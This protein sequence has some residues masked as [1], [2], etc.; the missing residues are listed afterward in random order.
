MI[1]HMAAADSP[2]ISRRSAH[3]ARLGKAD[4]TAA[5]TGRPVSCARRLEDPTIGRHRPRRLAAPRP[6]ASEPKNTTTGDKK[7]F[8]HTGPV[9]TTGGSTTSNFTAPA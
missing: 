6:T 3:L 7:R 1:R 5:S 2:R 9:L 4:P 8:G